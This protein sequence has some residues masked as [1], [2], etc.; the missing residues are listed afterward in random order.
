MMYVQKLLA[1][2][3]FTFTV[4]SVLYFQTTKLLNLRK[5]FS[6][7]IVHTKRVTRFLVTIRCIP[8]PK[9]ISAIGSFQMLFSIKKIFKK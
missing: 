6:I 1:I 7:N 3:L 5:S 9:I 8:T 2:H 4:T